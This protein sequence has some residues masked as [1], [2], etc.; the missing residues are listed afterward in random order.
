MKLSSEEPPLY[1]EGVSFRRYLISTNW[2]KSAGRQGFSL[3]QEAIDGSGMWRTSNHWGQLGKT[4]WTL[5]GADTMKALGGVEVEPNFWYFEKP[6][7]G[8]VRYEDM[9]FPDGTTPLTH[10]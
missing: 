2:L 6:V 8:F 9:I 10:R 4:S 3:Y 7:S 1:S 5:G